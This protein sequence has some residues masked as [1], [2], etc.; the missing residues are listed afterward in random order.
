M[1]VHT[2][3]FANGDALSAAFGLLTESEWVEDC[4]AEPELLRVRFVAAVEPAS[5]L[6][7]RIYL[8]GGLTWSTRASL[9]SEAPSPA[10]AIRSRLH[11]HAA[12]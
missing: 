7:E 3:C 2:L 10:E 8:R 1:F 5:D 4:L 6:I 11:D 12:S 9:Q